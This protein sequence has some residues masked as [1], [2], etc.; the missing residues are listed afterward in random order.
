MNSKVVVGW[1][2]VILL[3][4][5]LTTGYVNDMHRTSTPVEEKSLAD[6]PWPCFRGNLRHTGL[7]P[8]DTS[9]ENYI[10]AWRY[11][12]GKYVLFSFPVYSSPAIGSDGT[13]YYRLI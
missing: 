8:Y 7:S 9:A 4:G 5:S 11:R 12:T 6:T 13:I 2:L 10:L 1:L 3:F